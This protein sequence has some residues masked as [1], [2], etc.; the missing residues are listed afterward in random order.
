MAPACCRLAPALL[1]ITL[2]G[3]P[4][5]ATPVDAAPTEAAPLP[6]PSIPDSASGAAPIRPER[7]AV[8]PRV[9]S[10]GDLALQD[11][12]PAPGDAMS[13]P[14][15]PLHYP[16]AVASSEQDPWGWRFSTARGAWRMHT[17]LD[18][19]APEGTAV[20]AVQTGRVQRVDVIDGYGLT[21]LIDHGAGW[22]SLYGHLLNASVG[23]GESVRAG[24]PLGSVGQ[25]GNASTPHLH[26][27]LRQR[28]PQGLVA[29]DPTTLL[30]DPQGSDLRKRPA[31][32]TASAAAA[33]P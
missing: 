22:S 33:M 23:L 31:R 6:E 19:I 1:L 10:V 12:P 32:R 2:L 18:L 27:E 9:V 11:Q 29:V 13:R 3:V 17:G 4:T 7:P 24:Q 15:E 8:V 21:V 5:H 14:P 25:S 28:Q 20:L 26:L 30:P 16:L